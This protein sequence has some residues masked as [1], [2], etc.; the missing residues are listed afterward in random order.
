MKVV[1]IRRSRGG[2]Y[3]MK[4]APLLGEV[5]LEGVRQRVWNF[6]YVGFRDFWPILKIFIFRDDMSIWSQKSAEIPGFPHG[7]PL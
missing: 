3:K 6:M 7:S 1:I 4:S 5:V 2:I